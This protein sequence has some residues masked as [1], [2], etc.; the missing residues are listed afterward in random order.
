MPAQ[1]SQNN[2]STVA[3]DYTDTKSTL[4]ILLYNLKD[5]L[6][7]WYIQMPYRHFRSLLR[8][9]VVMDDK[10]SISL[11]LKTFG[12]PWRRDTQLVG[13]FMGFAVRI[14]YLPIAIFILLLVIT[15]YFAF[16]LAWLLVPIVSIIFIILTPFIKG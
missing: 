4:D 10:F 15:G 1:M 13:Y 9:I 7:W 12:V 6:F 3:L 11:L 2:Q 14:I 16:I 8:I 5:F